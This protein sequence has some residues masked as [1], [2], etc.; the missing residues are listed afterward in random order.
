MNAK[1]FIMSSLPF[2]FNVFGVGLY[3]AKIENGE[4]QSLNLRKEIDDF[5]E[6]LKKKNVD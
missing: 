2:F 4:K 6:G 5:F 3:F 1:Y